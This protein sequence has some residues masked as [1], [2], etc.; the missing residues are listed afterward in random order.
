[1][2][3]DAPES[4]QPEIIPKPPS[5]PVTSSLLIASA[6]AILIAIGFVWSEL[7]GNYLVSPKT[8]HEVGMEKHT[9][10]AMKKSSGPIDHYDLD[11]PGEKS[12]VNLEYSV[13]KD[14]HLTSN[15]EEGAAAPAP[16]GQ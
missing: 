3:D 1:M 16:G 15:F 2:A 4:E 13:K 6:V 12:L 9:P 11:Y 8:V 14:L 5:H 7:F 10:D